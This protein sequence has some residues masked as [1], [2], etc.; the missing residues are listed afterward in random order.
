VRLSIVHRTRYR[1]AREVGFNPH[2]LMLRPRGGADLRVLQHAL[3]VSP[4]A[5]VAWS[6]DVFG[7]L[8]A[9]AI[10]AGSA[11]ELAITS[12]LELEASA[13]SW[14]IF[15]I[16]PRAHAYPYEH[17]KDEIL[18]L[19][20]LCSGEAVDPAVHAWAAGFILG[21]R[22]DTL[23]LL[24]DVNAGVLAAAAYR[25]RDEEGTQ[26]A[27]ETLRIASGSCRD[28]A[29]LFVDAVRALG[30]GAR[31]A[32]GYLFDPEEPDR[33]SDT[34]H[35][36]AEVFLPGAGWI[37]FDPT[38]GRT[39]GGGLIGVSVGRC[40]AQILPITGSYVGEQRDFVGMDVQ[41]DIRR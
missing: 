31:A 40:N 27:I 2:R 15:P 38:H 11:S 28:L 19:G 12:R 1:Y 25:A 18:D 32:S 17:T 29:A 16:D 26:S 37:A 21:A 5:K 13:P 39:G 14:P 23:S 35:A 9:H 24:K 8:V 4:A 22:T 10:I 3:E 20:A 41:V 6:Q 30:F 7:N 36:W 33:R 34:T